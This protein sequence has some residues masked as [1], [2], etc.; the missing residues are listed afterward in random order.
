MTEFSQYL[1]EMALAADNAYLH[2]MNTM[3]AAQRSQDIGLGGD[4]TPTMP[5]VL[6]N[7]AAVLQNDFWTSAA[8]SKLIRRAARGQS[9]P[10]SA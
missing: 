3:T 7:S 8:R 10:C 9:G 6:K 1:R 4:G 5:G 2:A